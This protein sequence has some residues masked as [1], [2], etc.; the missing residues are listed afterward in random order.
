[1]VAFVVGFLVW[2]HFVKTGENL[3]RGD[4]MGGS[5]IIEAVC[6]GSVVWSW[7]PSEVYSRISKRNSASADSVTM[8]N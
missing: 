5:N 2:H 1:M 6:V 7:P 4:G 3:G 8:K